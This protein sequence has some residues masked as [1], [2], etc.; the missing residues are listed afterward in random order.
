MTAAQIVVLAGTLAAMVAT[1][2]VFCGWMAH[3]V[4]PIEQTNHGGRR[5]A[6]FAAVVPVVVAVAALCLFREVL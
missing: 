5:H 4:M 3:N 6:L 1:V 2:G